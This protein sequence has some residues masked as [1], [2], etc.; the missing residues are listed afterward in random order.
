M[1]F[2]AIVASAAALYL[3]H[4]ERFVQKDAWFF[5]LGELCS[6]LPVASPITQVVSI[7]LPVAAVY[8]L[9]NELQGRLFG[10]LELALMLLVLLFS[11]GRNDL[12]SLL[13]KYRRSLRHSDIQSAAM[14]VRDVTKATP[15][16]DF[17]TLQTMVEQWSTY[18]RFENWF[19]VVFWFLLLGPAGAL[20][21]RLVQ[22]T[23]TNKAVLGNFLEMLDWIPVRLMGVSFAVI[24]DFVSATRELRARSLDRTRADSGVYTL[25]CAALQFGP[26]TELAPLQGD[27]RLGQLVD[28][29]QRSML[30]WLAA[31]AIAQIV[32]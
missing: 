5:R 9:Q 27:M 21:Y 20:A 7:L 6:R 17:S 2:L 11:L 23:V 10:M 12:N 13:L 24:G 14:L 25:A 3:G 22:L 31:I 1:E 8:L 30:L 15:P 16:D 19:A 29:L 26:A 28:L 32:L 4:F 18:R